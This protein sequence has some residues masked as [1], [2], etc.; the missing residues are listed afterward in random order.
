ME[1]STALENYSQIQNVGTLFSGLHEQVVL[2]VP[3]FYV[4]FLHQSLTM[5][6][7]NLNFRPETS[8]EFFFILSLFH[9]VTGQ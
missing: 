7:I 6:P 2:F 5:S 4:S 9:S 1:N 3:A 8:I